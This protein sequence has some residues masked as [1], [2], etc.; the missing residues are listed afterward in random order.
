MCK[1]FIH[2]VEELITVRFECY[3]ALLGD[4]NKENKK[5]RSHMAKI[6]NVTFHKNN[7]PARTSM[8]LKRKLNELTG[9]GKG[10]E[11]PNRS[12]NLYT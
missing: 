6:E 5:R 9:R 10:E 12:S 4:F 3:V 2:C 8:K 11:N 7:I 1:L